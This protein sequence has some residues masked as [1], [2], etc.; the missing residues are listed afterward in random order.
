MGKD[1]QFSLFNEI[2]KAESQKKAQAERPKSARE[3][4]KAPPLSKTAPFSAHTPK[5]EEKTQEPDAYS[6]TEICS[7]LKKSLKEGFSNILVRGEICDFKGV[8][9]SGHLYCSIKDESSQIRLVMWKAQVQRMPYDL[10]GGEEVLIHA[11]M[12]FYAGSGSIQLVANKIELV[13]EG[14]LHKKFEALK[15]QLQNEGLFSSENKKTI[16]QS[17]K[18]IAIVSGKSTAAFQDILKVYSQR[19][20]L[21]E[22]FLFHAAVQG[23]KAPQEII[24][25]LNTVEKFHQKKA[26]DCIVLARGGGSY[27]DL[28]CFNDEAL[29]RRIHA[30]EIPLVSGVGH[31]IDSTIC[32]YVADLRAAT[33]SQ[34]AELTSVDLANTKEK[35]LRYLEKNTQN[36]ESIIYYLQQKADS[37]LDKLMLYDPRRQLREKKLELKN[38][39]EKII[40]NIKHKIQSLRHSIESQAQLLDAYSPLKVLGRGYSITRNSK[41]QVI[42]NAK[43]AEKEKTLEILFS[44][45]AVQCQ[46][47]GKAKTWNSS[48]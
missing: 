39:R 4:S 16:P 42:K 38:Y 20:P 34:A 12:D 37:F 6:V 30:L 9:R 26:I 35:L 14:L 3:S 22:I 44:D 29:A 25:A 23:E 40:L 10:E 2:I 41:A 28:F 15:K 33:P 19:N 17:P 46:I 27:E 1:D 48:D 31:E 11:K 8:H 5:K 24:Q 32:D 18:R 45:A 7:K 43:E 21:A 36:I 13:G 47:I